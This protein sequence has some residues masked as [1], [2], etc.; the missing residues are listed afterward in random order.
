[1]TP[2]QREREPVPARPRAARRQLPPQRGVALELGDLLRVELLDDVRG[3]VHLG[4]L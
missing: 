3:E 4:L 1:M 2:V